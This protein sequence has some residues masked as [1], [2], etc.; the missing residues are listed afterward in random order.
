M[1]EGADDITEEVKVGDILDRITGMWAKP[2]Q[3]RGVVPKTCLNDA[4]EPVTIFYRPSKENEEKIRCRTIEW[5]V[6]GVSAPPPSFFSLPNPREG[7]QSVFE[8]F[9]P[10]RIL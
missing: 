8:L 10:M 2:F 4:N 7:R 5:D 6:L 9:V 3:R 1:L